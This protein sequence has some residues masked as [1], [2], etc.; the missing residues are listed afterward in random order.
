MRN[1]TFHFVVTW[2]LAVATVF[3]GSTAPAREVEDIQ[4]V[5]SF[6][7]RPIREFRAAGLKDAHHI[8]QDAAVRHLPGYDTNAAPGIQLRG[9]STHRR[10][11]QH[12]LA[13]QAQRRPRG[14]TY[15]A[16]RKI[17]SE[18]LE[19]AGVPRGQ[20]IKILEDTDDYFMGEL[21]L[22]M[23]TPLPIPG[24]R[25][26]LVV[27]KMG[28]A[29]VD[30][31]TDFAAKLEGMA[32]K[33]GKLVKGINVVFV[34]GE[35]GFI[36]YQTYRDVSAFRRGELDTDIIVA[37]TGLRTVETGLAIGGAIVVFTGGGGVVVIAIIAGGVAVSGA[38]I[39]L[40]MVSAA[41]RGERQRILARLEREDQFTITYQVL[42][43]EYRNKNGLAR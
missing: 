43:Q 9:P 4:K 1:T 14:G 37:K 16:E 28:S 13:T 34:V 31:G 7:P 36:A 21:G 39:G 15:A 8:I 40:D 38:D 24:N 22:K 41:R 32:A 42:Q 12:Y 18:A 2:W 5:A 3:G 17:G 19:A 25:G 27:N 6:A 26:P 20:I 10:G 35:F 11:T 30:I 29:G 33:T 23:D